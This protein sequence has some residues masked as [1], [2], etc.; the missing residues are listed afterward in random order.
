M[1]E[2]KIEAWGPAPDSPPHTIITLERG[3]ALRYH[4]GLAALPEYSRV[5]VTIGG[6]IFE[7]PA[8]RA[9]LP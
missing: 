1:P 5:T 9:E 7:G 4:A 3:R 8:L 6:K 2:Y